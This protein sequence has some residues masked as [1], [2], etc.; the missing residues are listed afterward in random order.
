MAKKK[1]VVTPRTRTVGIVLA[2]L[3]LLGLGI[4][5]VY[6]ASIAEGER[7]FHNRYHF[8]TRHAAW[9]GVGLF[10]MA[11][12]SRIPTSWI[13]RLA[14]PFFIMSVVLLVVVIVPGIGSKAQGATRWIRLSTGFSFQPSELAKLSAILYFATWLPKKPRFFNVLIVITALF[15]GLILQ[16][17]LG[18]ALVLSTTLFLMYFVSGAP[19]LPLLLGTAG[20][21]LGVL[22]LIFSSPYRRERL[23][24]FL[25]PTSDLLG[26]SYHVNQALIALGSGGLTGVG[27]GRSRQKFQYLPEATTDSIFAV[28]GEELGLLGTMTVLLL[29]FV[30]F[31]QLYR[32]VRRE[33]NPFRRLVVFGVTAWLAGQTIL[34]IASM[35]GLLPLTGVPLP[36]ISYGGSSIMTELVAMGIILRISLTHT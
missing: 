23:M 13:R 21:T 19:I 24:T 31:F 33:S 30:L 7:L 35:V 14:F 22:G 29:F 9:V 27:L 11:V 4:V 17:D 10:L 5:M 12:I 1:I 32:I 8:V 2:L 15:I 3:I 36:L 26:S 34:N 6:D 25:N 18:T 28:I 20:G 16:P